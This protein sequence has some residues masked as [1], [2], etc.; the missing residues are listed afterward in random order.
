MGRKGGRQTCLEF[1]FLNKA[2]IML[3]LDCMPQ[4]Q[5]V[6]IDVSWLVF[7]HPDIY[8]NVHDFKQNVRCKNINLELIGFE[9]IAKSSKFCVV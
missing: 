2:G 1:T 9:N 4:N 5:H 6:V 3:F 7:I 8:N